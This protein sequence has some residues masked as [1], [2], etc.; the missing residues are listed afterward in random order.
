V[1]QVWW[2]IAR[3]KTRGVKCV[4]TRDGQI[5]LVRHTYGDGERWD[6]P[7]GGIK[8]REEPGRAA[9]REIREELGIDVQDWAMLGELFARIDGRRDQ[10][11]CFSSEIGDRPVEIDRA[12]IAEAAWFPRGRLPAHTAKHVSR[13]AAMSAGDA[14]PTYPRRAA[15]AAPHPGSRH[16]PG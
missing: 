10:L 3:P 4:L 2:L 6:L 5:L 11:W 14:G 13:I 1:L 15:T 12:E 8:R 16:E 9:R 7:G